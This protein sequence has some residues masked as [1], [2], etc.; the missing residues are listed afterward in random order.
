M[1][2]LRNTLL[3]ALTLGLTSARDV[4]ANV[5]SFYD[6][7]RAQ[8]QCNHVLASKFHSIEGDSGGE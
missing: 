2:S 8:K 7:I 3:A 5:K 6:G 1:P 4:P